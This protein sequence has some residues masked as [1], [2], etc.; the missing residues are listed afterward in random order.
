MHLIDDNGEQFFGT[1]TEFTNA[2][3]ARR[4]YQQSQDLRAACGRLQANL[5]PARGSG[6]AAHGC[7]GHSWNYPGHC[8]ISHRCF[9]VQEALMKTALLA[10]VAALSVLS[11]SVAYAADESDPPLPRFRPWQQVWQ[12]NDIRV[13]ITA[14]DP[15]SVEYDLGGTIWGG[16][17]FTVIKG[18]LYF[19]ERPCLPLQPVGY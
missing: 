5:R 2:G 8:R 14:R 11:T 4:A 1:T 15:F 19:N 18:A 10:S 9:N 13:T 12:C 7:S 6:T 17:H 16:G 3:K